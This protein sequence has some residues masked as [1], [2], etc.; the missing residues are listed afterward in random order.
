MRVAWNAF[1]SGA[2]DRHVPV[3]FQLRDTADVVGVVMC[4]QNRGEPE[5]AVLEASFD[6]GAIAG[7]Y[8]SD[9]SRISR[10]VDEP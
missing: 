3:F 2:E 4:H 9:A 10:R 7:V 1:M 6:R 8:D 5:I